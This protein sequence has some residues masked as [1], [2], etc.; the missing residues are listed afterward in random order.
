MMRYF[1]QLAL[2]AT[3]LVSLPVHIAG[4]NLVP[5]GGFEELDASCQFGISYDGVADWRSL[6]CGA[7]PG[8]AHA[9]NNSLGNGSGVPQGGLGYQQAHGGDAFIMSVPYFTDSQGGVPDG[10]PQEYANVDLTQPLDAGQLYC[11]RFWMNLADSTCYRTS[12][13]HARVGYGV[14]SLCTNADT[15]WDDLA[16][17]TFDISAVDTAEW[18]MFETEFIANGGETNLTLGAFQTVDEIE[19]TFLADHIQLLGALVAAYFIDDVELWACQVGINQAGAD[20]QF[21]LYPNP[22]DVSVTVSYAGPGFTRVELYDVVGQLITPATW[23]A[24]RSASGQSTFDTSGIPSGRYVV[25]VMRR[26]PQ[27]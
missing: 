25:R 3:C 5:N 16:Q 11:L 9:C 2:T 13:F 8:Y 6:A 27:A 19:S 15:A 17:A 23:S 22:A 12:V 14:P 24:S 21:S 10:N 18:T 20:Q 1:I 7:T 4:Q 26:G